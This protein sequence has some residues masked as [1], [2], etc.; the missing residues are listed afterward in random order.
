MDLV[1]IK[2]KYRN[3]R[4]LIIAAFLLTIFIILLIIV[5][6]THLDIKH[7][8]IFH[9]YINLVEQAKEEEKRI[10]QQKEAERLA[11][12]P[13]LTEVGKNNL[14]NIYNSETKRVFLTFDDGPS[15]SVTIPILDILKQENV[16]ATF[17][18]L[19][20]RV[21]LY[22]DIV[23]RQY[24]EGHYLASH[25]YSHVYSQIY[26]SPN[27]V[28]DEYNRCLASIKNAIGATEFNPHLFRFPG[29]NKGGKYFTI[30][31]Q[32][33]VLLEQNGVL[34][35]DWNALTADSAGATTTEQFIVELEKEVPKYNSVVVLMHDAG[36]KQATAEALPT[37]IQYFRERGFEFENFYSIIK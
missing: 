37:I 22:P 7:E 26:A 6:E 16:K 17:F 19:G 36:T 21:D 18:L 1:S 11:K 25:G 34:N 14:A 32:A 3:R 24:D 8:N 9:S 33:A 12:L 5:R 4:N 29:G 30:K 28:L 10:A 13:Q 2:R 20:S 31:E 23:K 35:I 15:K 27:S